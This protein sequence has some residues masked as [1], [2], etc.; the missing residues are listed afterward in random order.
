MTD[1][2]ISLTRRQ[3][4]RSLWNLL[5]N[6]TILRKNK[7]LLVKACTGKQTLMSQQNA[8]VYQALHLANFIICHFFLPSSG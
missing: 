3:N 7:Y 1:Q 2:R 4:S 5:Y 6:L 8:R